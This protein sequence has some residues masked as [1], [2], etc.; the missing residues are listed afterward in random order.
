M[1][2]VYGENILE[3]LKMATRI[4]IMWNALGNPVINEDL[5]HKVKK[6]KEN[7]Q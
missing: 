5:V 3:L 1:S 4:F 6:V 2:E 7:R